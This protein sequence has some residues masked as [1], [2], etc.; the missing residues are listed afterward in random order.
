MPHAIPDLAARG[1]TLIQ[2]FLTAAEEQTLIPLLLVPSPVTR[3]TQAKRNRVQRYGSAV[4]YNSYILSATIPD[5]FA[6]LGQRL[7]DRG[8]LEH[9]PDSVTVN[10]YLKGDIIPAHVDAPA[11][12]P[13]ITVL[14]LG[15]TARMR[16]E[17]Q[18]ISYTVDL[19]PRSLIQMRGDVRY[20]WTHEIL[21]V[22]TK[23]YSVV[24]RCSKECAGEKP[25]SVSAPPANPS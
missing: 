6:V 25:C 22:A 13:V 3:R 21:P 1:L 24:F 5:H 11:G 12:G 15:S 4:P 20:N 14:S 10:E 16:L 7:V 2:E 8:L 19:P 17:R 23:R 9:L 18:K